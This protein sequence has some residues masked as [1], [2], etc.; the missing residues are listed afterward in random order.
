M[1]TVLRA[2]VRVWQNYLKVTSNRTLTITPKIFWKSFVTI[3]SQDGRLNTELLTHTTDNLWNEEIA[4]HE[5]T[6]FRHC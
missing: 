3:H 5:V 6:K 2:T 4:K 1:G